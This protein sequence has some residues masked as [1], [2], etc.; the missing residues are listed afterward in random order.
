MFRHRNLIKQFTYTNKCVSTNTSGHSNIFSPNLLK[1]TMRNYSIIPQKITNHKINEIQI[2]NISKFGNLNNYFNNNT[3]KNNQNTNNDK[4]SEEN[5][6][7]N[8]STNPIHEKED[9]AILSAYFGGFF[10]FLTSDES[11][12]KSIFGEP[13]TILFC[14]SMC[15]LT[16]ACGAFFTV[17]ILPTQLLF[18]IP[19]FMGLAVGNNVMKLIYTNDKKIE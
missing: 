8:T 1:N 6:K 19:T 12:V 4:Y 15:G 3:N 17:M 16:S 13:M 7:E 2:R 18:A 5:D 9:F 11:V 14:S 10:F